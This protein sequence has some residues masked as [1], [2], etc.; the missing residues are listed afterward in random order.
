[1]KLLTSL[2]NEIIRT[3]AIIS[4]LESFKVIIDSKLS[5][6]KSW[7]KHLIAQKRNGMKTP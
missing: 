5:L 3:Y 2:D 6:N 4:E 1:M 7:L